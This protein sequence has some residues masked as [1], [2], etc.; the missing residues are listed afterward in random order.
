LILVV[1]VVSQN[2]PISMSGYAM[3]RFIPQI[4]G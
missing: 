4:P 1:L 3:F 2:G